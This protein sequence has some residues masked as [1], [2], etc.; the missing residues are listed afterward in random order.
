MWDLA[1]RE[2]DY[3]GADTMMRRMVAP[4]LSMRIPL[5]FVRDDAPG[6]DRGE[7]FQPR[8]LDDDGRVDQFRTVRQWSQRGAVRGDI[9]P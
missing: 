5:T 2:E 1:V 3:S 8:R 6:R 7:R 9:G 4:P